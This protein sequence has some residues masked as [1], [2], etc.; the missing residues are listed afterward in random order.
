MEMRPFKE[1]AFVL[2]KRTGCGV[3]PI[4]HTGSEKTFDRGSWV[5]K[6]K[7]PIYI[8]ILDEIPPGQVEKLEVGELHELTRQLMEEGLAR[9]EKEVGMK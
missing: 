7:A 2:A 4:V 9:L 5:L 3:I 6:G 1:G 8:R